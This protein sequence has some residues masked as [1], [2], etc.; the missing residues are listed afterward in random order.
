MCRS[1]KIAQAER[2]TSEGSHP[3]RSKERL[4]TGSGTS[5]ADRAELRETPALMNVMIGKGMTIFKLLS[6]KDKALLVGWDL[7]FVL[8]FSFDVVYGDG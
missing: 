6:G 5:E 1:V 3:P 4:A 7:F 8:N 2:A